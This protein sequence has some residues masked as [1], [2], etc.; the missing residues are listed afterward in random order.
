MESGIQNSGDYG[1]KSQM[2]WS[3]KVAEPA[4]AD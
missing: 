1:E 3:E 4:G 2:V